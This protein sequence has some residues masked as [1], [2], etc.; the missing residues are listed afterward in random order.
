MFRSASPV[1]FSVP[2]IGE[3]GTLTCQGGGA[4]PVARSA[5]AYDAMMRAAQ[6]PPPGGRRP[7]VPSG[8]VERV[9]P[10]TPAVFVRFDWGRYQVCLTDGPHKGE[11]FWVG[12]RFWESVDARPPGPPVAVPP[13]AS[14]AAAPSLA[15]EGRDRLR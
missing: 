5:A 4:I 2:E 12:E 14:T 11:R 9:A 7:P 13:S 10:G 1:S 6:E 8:Q 15:S 3:K